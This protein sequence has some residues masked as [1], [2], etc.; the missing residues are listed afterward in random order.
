MGEQ[1]TGPRRNSSVLAKRDKGAG[2]GEG[3]ESII[4][5][6]NEQKEGG[7]GTDRAELGCQQL[8]WLHVDPNEGIVL[9]AVSQQRRMGYFHLLTG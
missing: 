5:L 6:P 3:Q 8:D 1:P 7:P 4:G 9:V 2:S